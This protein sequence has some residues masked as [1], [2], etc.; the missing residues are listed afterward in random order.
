[1]SRASVKNNEEKIGGKE[2]TYRSLLSSVGDN[3]LSMSEFARLADLYKN[4]S[5]PSRLRIIIELASGAL[6]VQDIADRLGMSQSA[7]SHQLRVLRGARLVRYEKEGKNVVYAL[8][9]EH[10]EDI[11]KIGVEHVRH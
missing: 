2:V 6:C 11:L 10:I 1:M 5:D 3:A 9:D 4:F 7:I 8:D